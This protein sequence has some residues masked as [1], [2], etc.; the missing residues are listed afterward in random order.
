MVSLISCQRPSALLSSYLKSKE[1]Y[2][3]HQMWVRS[4]ELLTI[5]IFIHITRASIV[6]NDRAINDVAQIFIH[7]NR[8]F[9]ANSNEKIH[10]E[11]LLP[12]K[13]EKIVRN[14]SEIV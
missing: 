10:K 14:Q 8:Y 5:G 3:V 7:I 4:N 12:T 13:S 6:I 9:I 11:R 1:K 2:L